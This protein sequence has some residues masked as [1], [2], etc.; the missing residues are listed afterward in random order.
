MESAPQSLAGARVWSSA[1]ASAATSTAIGTGKE[2][3]DL[4]NAMSGGSPASSLCTSITRNG[5]SDWYLPSKDEM[6]QLG[7]V[8]VSISAWTDQ[9]ALGA[10]WTSSQINSTNVWVVDTGGGSTYTGFT[11]TDNRYCTPV[12]RFTT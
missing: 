12:R 3:T 10:V 11:K 8:G 7:I 5:K 1:S 4:M 9:G 6:V 2:N